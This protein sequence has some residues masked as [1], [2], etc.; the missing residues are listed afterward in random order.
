MKLI[1]NILAKVK[2]ML[3]EPKKHVLKLIMHVQG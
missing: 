1:Q 2:A 3:R